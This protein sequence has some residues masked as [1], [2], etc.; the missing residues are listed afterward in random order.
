MPHRRR[1]AVMGAGELGYHLA[2]TLNQEGHDVVLIDVNADRRSRIE[3]ELD[4]A[5]IVGNGTQIPVLEQANVKDCELFIAASN[6]EEANLTASL[7]AKDLGVARTAARLENTEELTT[8]RSRYERLF[9]VD[10]LLSPQVLATTQILN[11]VLGHN[12]HEVDFLAQGKIQLRTIQIQAGCEATQKPLRAVPMPKGSLIVGYLD[13]THSLSIPSADQRPVAGGQALVLCTESAARAVERLFSSRF[14]EPEL[15]VV[16]GAGRKGLG[17]ARALSGA[18]RRIKLIERDRARAERAAKLLPEVEV[19]HGDATDLSL[20]R[21]ERADRPQAYIA[22]MEQ[23]ETNLLAGLIA[24]EAGAHHVIALVRRTETSRLWQRAGRLSIVSPRFL[25]AERITDYIRNGYK[26]NM[27][28]LEG[29]ALR[30][31]Q[32]PVFSASPVVG[33]SLEEVSPPQGLLVG[34]IVRDDDVFIP[35]GPDRLLEGDHAILFVHQS[36]LPTVQLLFPGPD[37][38]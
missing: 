11:L 2:R 35:S 8:Y 14:V 19:L 16:A 18:V 13:Q 34:A 25:A 15:V 3:D 17:I 7:L 37:E 31:L 27:I 5:F 6:S 26:P 32:R 24:Q 36:E 20:L 38:A 1:F 21:S 10:L 29:G 4:L 23:D 28:S 22:A 33:A 9:R 12:T 30:V